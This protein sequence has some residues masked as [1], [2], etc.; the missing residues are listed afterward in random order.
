MHSSTL[1]RRLKPYG[2]GLRELV[3]ECRY[4]VAREMLAHSGLDVSHIAAMLD[5]ADASA[6]TRAFKRWSGSTPARWRAQQAQ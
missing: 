6:F 3:D 1:A 5:Y 4:E 2:V